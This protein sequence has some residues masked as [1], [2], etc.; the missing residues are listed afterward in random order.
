MS[1]T[2][3]VLTFCLVA[4]GALYVYVEFLR[5]RLDQQTELI[6]MLSQAFQRL[7]KEMHDRYH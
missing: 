1:F 2:S 4:I 5:G 3:I 7:E 6:A